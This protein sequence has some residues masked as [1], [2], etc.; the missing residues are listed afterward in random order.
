MSLTKTFPFSNLVNPKDLKATRLTQPSSSPSISDDSSDPSTSNKTKTFNG[1]LYKF[2]LSSTPNNYWG[3][4]MV[5]DLPDVTSVET[6][7]DTAT[8]S[9]VVSGNPLSAFVYEWYEN[10]ETV[11]P[12]V[13]RVVQDTPSGSILTIPSVIQDD[14]DSEFSVR[15]TN[16]YND[17][18]PDLV[19]YLTSN[20]SSLSIETPLYHPD[21]LF[22]IVGAIQ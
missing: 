14:V 22:T 6:D 11:T 5:E 12:S 3:P 19:N 2:V 20:T 9:V 17:P 13:T 21:V 4:D 18:A 16:P 1:A 7:G 10:G 8:F 15:I